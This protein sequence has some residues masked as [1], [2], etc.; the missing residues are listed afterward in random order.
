MLKK[1]ARLSERTGQTPNEIVAEGINLFEKQI[2]PEAQQSKPFLKPHV[3]KPEDPNGLLVKL[4]PDEQRRTIYR[5]VASLMLRYNA[6]QVSSDEMVRRTKVAVEN[7]MNN[8]PED[9]RKE[10]AKKAAEARWAK[11]REL[12]T[13]S[14]D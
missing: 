11:K 12:P 1:I 14:T 5:E 13:S 7:R 2:R 10:I 4:E 8:T 9:K 3:M 6:E